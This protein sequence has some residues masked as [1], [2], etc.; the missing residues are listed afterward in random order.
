[1]AGLKMLSPLIF[2]DLFSRKLIFHGM[3]NRHGGISPAPHDSL[4]VSYG[5]GDDPPQVEENRRCIKEHLGAEVLISGQQVHDSNIYVAEKMPE[6]DEELPGFDAFVTNI[7][8]IGLL[9]QQADC[10]AVMLFDP[11][12]KVIANIHCGWRGSV[13]NIIGKTIS[14]M[15]ER[16]SCNPADL[17]AAISPSLGP[18]CAEFVNYRDELP[19][20]LHAFQVKPNY[21]DFQ[22]ISSQQLCEAGV[23]TENISTASTC[24]VCDTDWFSYRREGTTGRFCSVIGI[25]TV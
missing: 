5:V 12:K 17:L 11:E 18:C 21:F 13:A 6:T 1:M 20:N 23:K 3:F 9:I 25:K 19:A 14:V 24:T 16:Y 7:P 22:A 2:P 8:G 4:N 10:Q 15:N